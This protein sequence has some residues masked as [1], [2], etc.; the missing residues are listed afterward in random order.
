M[1]GGTGGVSLAVAAVLLGVAF[2]LAI[3]DEESFMQVSEQ[4]IARFTLLFRKGFLRYLGK[5]VSIIG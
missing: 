3:I 5:L 2:F 4:L 1:T